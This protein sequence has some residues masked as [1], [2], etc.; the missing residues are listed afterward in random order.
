[1]EEELNEVLR[2][3]K[4]KKASAL[5]EIL[6]EVS[7]TRKFDDFLLRFCNTMYRQNTI[8]R[9]TKDCI[10]PFIKKGDLKITKNYR[11][12]ILTSIAA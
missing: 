6:P 8:E 3:I 10:F 2:K 11:G 12:I 1:M 7:K 4:S 5:D 9:W